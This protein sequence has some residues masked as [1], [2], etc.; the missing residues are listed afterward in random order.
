[1]DKEPD[2]AEIANQDPEAIR[3]QIEETRSSLTEKLE[4][5]EHE[6]KETVVGAKAAVTETVEAVKETVE[7]TVEAVKDTFD[8]RRQVCQHPWAMLGGSML[9]G[10]LV[11]SLLP[12]PRRW[13]GPMTWGRTG[14]TSERMG[15]TAGAETVRDMVRPTEGRSRPE[16]APGPSEPSL[17]S[18]LTD[19][20]QSEI[21][22]LK[23]I[24]IGAALGL[25]RDV[26]VRSLP[27]TLAPHIREVIDSVTTKLGGEPVQGPILPPPVEAAAAYA[28]C[29]AG[30]RPSARER[31]AAPA[32]F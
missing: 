1:M 23:G 9:C 11:G 18:D 31:A 6:V 10:F 21:N 19:T 16:P 25:L 2:V 26:A 4:T 20:F 12:R 14:R 5:L 24:A 22:E 27:S 8:L 7:N 17:L 29:C 13:G 30:A 3:S 32:L 15:P 28:T